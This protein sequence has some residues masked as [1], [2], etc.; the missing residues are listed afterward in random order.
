[1]RPGVWFGDCGPS[2]PRPARPRLPRRSPRLCL[3]PATTAHGQQTV[4]PCPDF[5]FNGCS[6]RTETLRQPASACPSEQ[7]G[8]CPCRPL[9]SSDPRVIWTLVSSNVKRRHGPSRAEPAGSWARGPAPNRPPVM[10]AVGTTA[11]STVRWSLHVASSGLMRCMYLFFFAVEFGSAN[12]GRRLQCF[13]KAQGALSH[14]GWAASL[15][16]HPW[17]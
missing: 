10:R 14:A 9:P 2:C 17:L 13:Q 12:S 6:G 1:M 3:P 5:S 11:T 16:P 15:P 8:A 4:E 7:P